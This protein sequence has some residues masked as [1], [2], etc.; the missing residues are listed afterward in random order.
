MAL[1]CCHWCSCG[2][3]FMRSNHLNHALKGGLRD[4]FVMRTQVRGISSTSSYNAHICHHHNAMV[5]P[6]STS[7]RR[8]SLHTVQPCDTFYEPHKYPYAK[9]MNYVHELSWCQMK[10]LCIKCWLEPLRP[11]FKLVLSQ[12]G[13][14]QHSNSDVWLKNPKWL[15]QCQLDHWILSMMNKPI[16][17][18]QERSFAQHHSWFTTPYC[19]TV[20]FHS[21]S[22]WRRLLTS[23]ACSKSKP[24]TC[25]WQNLVL[26]E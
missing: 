4:T 13:T 23:I 12:H 11:K 14:M 21:G 25:S 17:D 7:Q 2:D 3:R 19:F 15:L 8:G 6:T 1:T 10:F 22:M 26:T 18:K 5:N 24:S 9:M 16:L 20:W